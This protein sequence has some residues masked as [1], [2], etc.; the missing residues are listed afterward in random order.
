[1]LIGAEGVGSAHGFP[2]QDIAEG[3]MMVPIE[4]GVVASACGG[5]MNQV[6]LG[7]KR[8]GPE[9]GVIQ[10]FRIN[11]SLNGDERTLE[12]PNFWIVLCGDTGESCED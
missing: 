4:E 9:G 1:M 7:A 11:Y 12:I 6:V 10:G 2:P 5:S 8:T 3:S